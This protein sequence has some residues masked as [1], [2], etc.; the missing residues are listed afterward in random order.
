MISVRRHLTK[1]RPGLPQKSSENLSKEKE[2]GPQKTTVFCRERRGDPRT[3]APK[4]KGP[5]DPGVAAP[6]A[7]AATAGMR[8]GFS[9]R[10]AGGQ[11]LRACRAPN[12]MSYMA[13]GARYMS[14][15]CDRS[16]FLI[17]DVVNCLSSDFSPMFNQLRLATLCWHCRAS[18][19][20]LTRV[21]DF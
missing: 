1:N 15:Q 10:R 2:T 11:R 3:P 7:V 21:G 9:A 4:V 6:L 13:S 18:L 16:W 8:A 14:G 20:L 19:D 5:K 17:N 12:L